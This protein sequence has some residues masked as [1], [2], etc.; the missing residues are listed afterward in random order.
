MSQSVTPQGVKHIR[1]NRCLDGGWT[2]DLFLRDLS[3]LHL[4]DVF[5]KQWPELWFKGS[6]AHSVQFD[7]V[8]DY[9]A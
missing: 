4:L 7:R 9:I 3:R 5:E 1:L 8:A 2:K 6:F